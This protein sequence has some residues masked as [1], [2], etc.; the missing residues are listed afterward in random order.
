VSG[1]LSRAQPFAWPGKRR[2]D[3]AIRF[4]QLRPSPFRRT[5]HRRLFRVEDADPAWSFSDLAEAFTEPSRPLTFSLSLEGTPDRP[6]CRP[7]RFPWVTLPRERVTEIDLRAEGLHFNQPVRESWVK[8]RERLPSCRDLASRNPQAERQANV[9][10][11]NVSLTPFRLFSTRAPRQAV[12][13][14]SFRLAPCGFLHE[15]LAISEVGKAP[16]VSDQLLPPA[17]LMRAPVPREFLAPPRFS[18]REHPTESWAP[19]D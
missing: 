4:R 15:D 17:R 7:M 8:A 18:P 6:L 10:R 13:R 19:S 9:Y 5:T 14:A 3:E 11:L 16:D 1:A 2:V 12:L